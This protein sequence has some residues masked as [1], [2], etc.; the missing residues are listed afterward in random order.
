MKIEY[1]L[2]KEDKERIDKYKKRIEEIKQSYI[3]AYKK[4]PFLWHDLHEQIRNDTGIQILEKYIASIYAMSV[5]KY[6][7]TAESEEDKE[8]LRRLAESQGW[9]NEI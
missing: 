4:Q 3:D 9:K 8:R 5:G 1:V 2:P 6:I 7:V